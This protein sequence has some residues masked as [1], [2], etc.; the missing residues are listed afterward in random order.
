VTDEQ[1][2]KP[3]H[4][5]LSEPGDPRITCTPRPRGGLNIHR[6]NH[7]I[8][9]SSAEANRLKHAIN[10]ERIARRDGTGF[11]KD[12]RQDTDSTGKYVVHTSET[13]R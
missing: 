10:A 9:L 2:D 6:G 3:P 8:A 12:R 5:V 1:T 4:T 11:Y 13:P 7:H